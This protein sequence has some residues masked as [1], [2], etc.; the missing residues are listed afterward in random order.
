MI[1]TAFPDRMIDASEYFHL[2]V[3]EG[4]GRIL[5]EIPFE[6]AGLNVVVTDNLERYRRKWIV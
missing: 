1:E 4:P 5:E 6:K 3:L 2:W